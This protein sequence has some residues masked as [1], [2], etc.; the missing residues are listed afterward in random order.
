MASSSPSL[1][2]FLRRLPS[3]GSGALALYRCDCGS[4][5]ERLVRLV[6][7]GKTRSCGCWR[8]ESNRKRF[9]TH[10]GS[11]TPEY[12][13][14]WEMVQRCHDDGH[15]DYPLYGSRGITV[16]ERWRRSFK[17]FIDDMGPRPAGCTVERTD[18]NRGYSPSNCRWATQL[19]QANNRRNTV[20]ITANGETLSL[21]GWSLRLGIPYS[22]LR[23]RHQRG[24]SVDLMFSRPVGRWAA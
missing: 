18:N 22:T 21:R 5:V 2:K 4:E 14:W 19:E 20:K 9:T 16:C 24:W 12:R 11:K 3:R 13:V 1:L 17:N 10:G 8:A 23:T 6:E 15:H 7:A